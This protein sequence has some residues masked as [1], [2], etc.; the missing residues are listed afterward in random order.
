MA[1]RKIIVFTAHDQAAPGANT[2]IINAANSAPLT[3]P[4]GTT[5]LDVAVAL[6]TS[7]VFN[8]TEKVGADTNKYGLQESATLTAGDL[9][10]W[11]VEPVRP[12][13]LYDFEVETDGII[14]SLVVH[15][16]RS[17]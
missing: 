10:A 8:V 12:D 3:P 4:A 16:V 11:R 6:G 2:G 15:A 17:A 5:G 7:S 14:S 13:A 9:Y 1:E